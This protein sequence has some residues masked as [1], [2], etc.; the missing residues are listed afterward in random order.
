M[1]IS[2]TVGLISC[3]VQYDMT[4]L[5]KLNFNKPDNWQEIDAQDDYTYDYAFRF[6]S[7]EALFE[8]YLRTL[9]FPKKSATR[10]LLEEQAERKKR[11]YGPNKIVTLATKWFNWYLLETE[12]EISHKG[13]EIQ[14]KVRQY[15]A[16]EEKSPRLVQCYFVGE[17][18]KFV[19]LQENEVN[20]FLNSITLEE[21]KTPW[22]DS[23]NEY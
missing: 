16:K 21:I 9:Y 5:K 13:K 1:G 19:K 18:N 11:G 12:D 10:W 3:A 22:S 8:V 4:K 2:I 23:E 6:Q 17:K 15:A 7:D 14:I 20:T